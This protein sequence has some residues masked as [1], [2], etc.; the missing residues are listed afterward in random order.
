M[1]ELDTQWYGY[2][3]GVAIEVSDR[4][5]NPVH[6][7][8]SRPGTYGPEDP[9]LFKSAQLIGDRLYACSQTEAMIFSYPDFELLHHI[10]HP[11]FNDVHHA[12]PGPLRGPVSEDQRPETVCVVSSGQDAVIEVSLDGELVSMWR[13]DGEDHV[14]RVD[15]TRD[16]R[17]NTKLKPHTFHPNYLFR[18]PDGSLWVNRFETRDAVQ[19]G[20]TSRRIGINR[21]R[22]HDGVVLDD[23]VYF[24]TVDGHV[25]AADTE[26]FEVRFEQ[27][28]VGKRDDILLGWCRGLTFVGDYAI[29]GFSRIRHTKVRGALSW[30]RTG[31]TQP[32]PTRIAVY[33]RKSWALVDELDL[34]PA[35]CNAVFSII[36]SA[37]GTTT[38]GASD[39]YSGGAV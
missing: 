22:C 6:E 37:A 4:L 33:D 38:G 13:V 20:D 25:V 39:R 31:F 8:H 30:V 14:G 34:E 3:S 19:V 7:W 16:Y 18:M 26:T 21:E 2:G 17:I 28:L 35:G 32:A 29:V 11:L 12:V 10:S 5:A 36:S 15:M 1:R 23:L 9:V 27:P 24:T